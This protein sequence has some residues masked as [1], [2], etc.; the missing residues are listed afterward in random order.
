[1]AINI[2]EPENILHT[3][4]YW[5]WNIPLWNEVHLCVKSHQVASNLW[6]PYEWSPK[7]PIAQISNGRKHLFCYSVPN[8]IVDYTFWWPMQELSRAAN[9]MKW[10]RFSDTC[11]ELDFVIKMAGHTSSW[12]I[13]NPM[14]G[15]SSLSELIS[16]PHTCAQGWSGL[17]RYACICVG[18]MY[19]AKLLDDPCNILSGKL[20]SFQFSIH[21]LFPS[22][23][24]ICKYS[25]GEHH[26]SPGMQ[27]H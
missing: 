7:C 25:T 2:T 3:E 15:Y 13:C 5:S 8:V 19:N 21:R 4:Q 9:M 12:V 18:F 11:K 22:L 16:W 17:L 20:W 10:H 1:M 14:Q 6:G 26:S 27:I 24:H 23:S